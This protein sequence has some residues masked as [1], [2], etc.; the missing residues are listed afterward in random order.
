MPFISIIIPTYNHA[1]FLGRALTSLINQ[2]YSN[3]EAIIIDNHSQDG[4]DAVIKG[5]AD[6]RFRLLKIRNRGIIAASR[7]MGINAAKGEWVA[8]LDSDDWWTTDKLQRCFDRI[9]DSVD[10]IYHDLHV[11]SHKKSF[12]QRNNARTRQL[13]KP[14]LTDLLMNGNLISNSSVLLRK[15]LLDDVGCLDQRSQLVGAE[16]FNGWLKIASKTDK[17]L[18]LPF[19]LGFYEFHENGVSR[20]DMSEPYRSAVADFINNVNSSKRSL[21]DAH[22]SYMKGRYYFS[23][24]EFEQ[25]LHELKYSFKHGSA[26]IK[27]KS[28]FIIFRCILKLL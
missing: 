22:I 27:A 26:S 24:H 10:F 8:F 4:T 3:W 20:K 19:F 13:K 6:P 11:I 16:D 15:K 1:H 9:N 2:T 23:H 21:I 7:N 17:F 25:A 28:F 5:F 14:V 12:L 18:Y